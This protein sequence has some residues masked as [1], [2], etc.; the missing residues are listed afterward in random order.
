MVHGSVTVSTSSP[1]LNQ[2]ERSLWGISSPAGETEIVLRGNSAE[3]ISAVNGRVS[4]HYA[5]GSAPLQKQAAAYDFDVYSPNGAGTV[6]Y[7]HVCSGVAYNRDYDPARDSFS[8]DPYST[9][10][11]ALSQIQ[12][13]P[14]SWSLYFTDTGT[15][16]LPIV[17]P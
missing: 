2:A 5:M 11:S 6:R 7:H 3:A 14:T 13:R 12:F 16:A 9:I 17:H 1:A 8:A 10:G 15:I 4:L